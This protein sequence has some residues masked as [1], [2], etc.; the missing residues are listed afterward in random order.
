[1]STPVPCKHWSSYIV[2]KLLHYY[3]AI[4]TQIFH[5]CATTLSTSS[6]S[7]RSVQWTLCL[8]DVCTTWQ[9]RSMFSVVEVATMFVFV[10]TTLQF[11]LLHFQ[12]CQFSYQVLLKIKG[13]LSFKLSYTQNKFLYWSIQSL[14]SKQVF[15]YMAFILYNFHA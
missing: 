7:Y 15:T 4:Q 10:Q 5:F 13:R 14:C 12:C 3:T 9:R 6:L 1:M 2:K 8:Y 11:V